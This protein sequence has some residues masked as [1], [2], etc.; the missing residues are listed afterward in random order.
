MEIDGPVGCDRYQVLSPADPLY[1]VVTDQDS[2]IAQLLARSVHRHKRVD[3]LQQK[4]AHC[5]SP[6]NTM[7]SRSADNPPMAM[8]ED[9]VLF[10]SDG[11]A[12]SISGT[13]VTPSPDP[14]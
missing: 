2:G 10:R 12:S 8:P 9:S 7:L 11:S 3:V 4:G 6:G 13:N 1:G 5:R 14:I